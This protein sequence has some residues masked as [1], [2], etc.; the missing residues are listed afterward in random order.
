MTSAV[1][2]T[3]FAQQFKVRNAW[4]D[5]PM[6]VSASSGASVVE[7]SADILLS[8]AVS[9]GTSYLLKPASALQPIFAEVSGKRADAAKKLGRVQIGLATENVV[10]GGKLPMK[11]EI[12][13]MQA[14]ELRRWMMVIVLLMACRPILSEQKRDST[15]SVGNAWVGTWAAALVGADAKRTFAA[16][17]K[18]VLTLTDVI[19]V[20]R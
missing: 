5:G 19:L 18:A 3:G 14:H 6:D 16:F 4:P 15:A 12:S 13:M 7:A 9:G 20:R 11:S 17:P 10:K 8:F 2:E 1:I